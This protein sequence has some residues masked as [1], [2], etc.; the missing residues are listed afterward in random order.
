M[1]RLI[2]DMIVIVI[3]NLMWFI[4]KKGGVFLVLVLAL[5]LIEGVVSQSRL[6]HMLPEIEA[7]IRKGKQNIWD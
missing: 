6:E 7:V 2:V 4:D 1:I 3:Y 5:I